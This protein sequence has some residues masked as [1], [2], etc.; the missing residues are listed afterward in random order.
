MGLLYV[1]CNVQ[2]HQTPLK[3]TILAN[4][5]PL[6]VIVFHVVVA[7]KFIV[8]VYVLVIE[9]DNFKLQVSDIAALQANVQVKSQTQ[10]QVKSKS[11]TAVVA[12]LVTVHHPEAESK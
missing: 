1:S 8:Q 10:F 7:V 2:A 3:V 12:V 5:F 6:E 4:I 11:T 9:A